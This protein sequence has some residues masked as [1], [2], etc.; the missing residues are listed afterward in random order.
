MKTVVESITKK[1]LKLCSV[2]GCNNKYLAKGYC[3]KHYTRFIRHGS[4]LQGGNFRKKYNK[5]STLECLIENCDKPKRVG[6]YCSM[7]YERLRRHGDPLQVQQFQTICKIEGCKG[8]HE[9]LGYCALHYERLRNGTPLTQEKRVVDPTRG[10]VIL[11]CNQPH[12]GRYYCKIHYMEHIGCDNKSWD[13]GDPILEIAMANVRI[14]DDNTCKWYNC[15]KKTTIQ[16]HHIF[17]QS[18]YPELKYIESYMICYC[19]KHHK[20]WHKKR[21]DLYYHLIK[22]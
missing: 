12:W 11:N 17:P 5:T 10:C 13:Y 8:K 4:P 14:R 2:E 7:H 16:V 22:D 6:G 3:S 19:R 1:D 20:E 15:S 18:E 9:S 21:G